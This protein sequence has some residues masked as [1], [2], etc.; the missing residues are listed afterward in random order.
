[1]ALFVYEITKV[2]SPWLGVDKVCALVAASLPT[3]VS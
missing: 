1:M 3:G 2:K